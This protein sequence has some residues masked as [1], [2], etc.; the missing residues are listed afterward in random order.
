MPR[1]RQLRVRTLSGQERVELCDL[2]QAKY[3][4]PFDDDETVCILEGRA[5]NSYQELINLA[6]QD[7]YKGKD[8]L[9][10]TLLPVIAGG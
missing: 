1:L 4:I 2:E 3:L 7:P 9:E 5:I 8:I 10:I 6:G